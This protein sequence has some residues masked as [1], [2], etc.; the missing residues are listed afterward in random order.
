MSEQIIA[1]GSVSLT[2]TLKEQLGPAVVEQTTVCGPTAKNESEGGVQ[3]TVP[4]TLDIG[5][6]VTIAPHWPTSFD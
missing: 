4:Q 3:V 1:G 2:V 5:V 6:K